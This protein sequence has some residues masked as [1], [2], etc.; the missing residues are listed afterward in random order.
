[1]TAKQH[2]IK[3]ISAL[4]KREDDNRVMWHSGQAHTSV[5]RDTVEDWPLYKKKFPEIPLPNLDVSKPESISELRY[6]VKVRRP[7]L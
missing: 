1:M 3:R 2:N 4:M 5:D 7:E 6:S